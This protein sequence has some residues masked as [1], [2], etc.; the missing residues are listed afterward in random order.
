MRPW[1]LVSTGWA[2]ALSLFRLPVVA[3]RLH[4]SLRRLN[5]ARSRAMEVFKNELERA[6]LPSN[7]AEAQELATGL[8]RPIDQADCPGQSF[9]Q[10]PDLGTATLREQGCA[11]TAAAQKR[12][13]V[14]YQR[15]SL[16]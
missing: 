5:K 13:D 3:A 7:D 11:A 4:G 14:C 1:S 16:G 8:A 15:S 2:I 9:R 6:G 12:E 10:S